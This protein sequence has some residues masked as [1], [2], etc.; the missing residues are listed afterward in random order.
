MLQKSFAVAH[1]ARAQGD[2]K[3]RQYLLQQN[4]G[5]RRFFDSLFVRCLPPALSHL[6]PPFPHVLGRTINAIQNL[7]V[8]SC[9][10]TYA[11]Y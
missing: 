4:A 7:R 5:P 3:A 8:F 1:K 6:S 2:P 9:F 10:Q 11:Y